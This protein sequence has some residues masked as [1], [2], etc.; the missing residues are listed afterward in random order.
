MAAIEI[1]NLKKSFRIYADRGQS[2]KEKLLSADRRRYQKRT[3]LD[4]ISLT[5]ASI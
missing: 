5:V 1:E 3:V 4:G 2:L